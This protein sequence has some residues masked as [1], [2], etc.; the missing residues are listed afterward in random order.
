MHRFQ[1]SLASGLLM[2]TSSLLARRGWLRPTDWRH[3]A[4]GMIPACLVIALLA[5]A[6]V[7]LLAAIVGYNAAAEAKRVSDLPDLMSEIRYLLSTEELSALKYRLGPSAEILAQ[8]RAASA[9]IATDLEQALL[10]AEP[11]DRARIVEVRAG[12]ASYLAASSALFSAVNSQNPIRASQIASRLADPAFDR[13]QRSTVAA[14]ATFLSREDKVDDRQTSMLF[15]MLILTP[16]VLVLD[17]GLV[18]TMFLVRRANNR[19]TREAAAREAFAVKRS[20]SRFRALVQNAADVMLITTPTGSITY[21]GPSAT[22]VWGYPESELLGT[23]LQDLIDPADCMRAEALW[24]EVSATPEA[25]GNLELKLLLHDGTW[26]HIELIL[27]NLADD[28]SVG[29]IVATARNIEERKAFERQLTRRAFY[30]SLTGLPNRLLFHDRLDHALTRASRHRKNAALL[31][32]DLDN[33][34]LINDSLGHAAGDQLLVE[35]AVRLSTCG[36]ADDTVARLGG[37]E[38]VV[39]LDCIASEADARVVAENIGRQFKRPFM[40]CDRSVVVTASIGIALGDAT[41]EGADS[42]LRNADVAMYRAK[43]NGKGEHVVFDA[44]MHQDSLARL[45][46]EADLR[47]A[48]VSSELRLHYQPIVSLATGRLVEVEALVRWQHPTRG[49]IMP[50]SFIAMAEETGL[51]VPLG[52]WVLTEACRQAAQWASDFPHEPALTLSVNLSPRQFQQPELDR[53]IAQILHQTGMIASRLKLEIT[54]GLI[55]RDVDRTIVM[56]DKLKDLGITLAV[57]DFGTG[58]SSLAYLKRLPLDVLKIDQSFI[59]GMGKNQEDTAIVQAIMSMAKSLNL[60]VTGEGIET[61]EQAAAL[62]ALSCDR[63]QGYFYARPL[64]G[65]CLTALLNQPSRFGISD[66][67]IEGNA[68]EELAVLQD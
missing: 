21:Q 59:R 16:L 54:E 51:I 20:E 34:K 10:E 9:T 61:A 18:V 62:H 32:I 38:F 17:L 48:L 6:I 49:L 42:L 15:S 39:L 3:A 12:H 19:R 22:T 67:T 13:V 57:D 4:Y 30:D 29:G 35:A 53:E 58:Y 50:A 31:F 66:P 44:S 1:T 8:Q 52:H 14:G 25:T 55:M 47:R 56:L 23:R 37:D 65:E 5:P 7:A 40:L 27:T 2:R 45:E 11:S 43:S 68:A 63:G 64:D 36:R 26:R 24:K 41:Q 46:L 28:P 60:L 33:F